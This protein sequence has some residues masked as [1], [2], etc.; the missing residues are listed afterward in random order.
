LE[1]K[2]NGIEN[3]GADTILLLSFNEHEVFAYD[4]SRKTYSYGDV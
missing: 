4:D 3:L 1:G 2:V